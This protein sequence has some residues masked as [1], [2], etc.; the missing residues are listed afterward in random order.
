MFKLLHYIRTQGKL[1]IY[2]IEG[3]TIIFSGD[4]KDICLSQD[5]LE[6]SFLFKDRNIN[7]L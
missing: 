4:L 3:E 6:M 2:I 5:A 1:V 7:T